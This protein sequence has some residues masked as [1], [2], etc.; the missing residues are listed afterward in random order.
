MTLQAFIDDSASDASVGDYF[1]LAGHVASAEQ[2]VKCSREWAKLLEWAPVNPLTGTH[3]FKMA[4]MASNEE[5]QFRTSAFYRIIE[6]NVICSVSVRLRL[7][8]LANAKARFFA[9]HTKMH[10]QFFKTPFNVAFKTLM[11]QFHAGKAAFA[12]EIPRG[13]PVN[14]IFD[15]QSEKA[16]IFAVW[17]EYL[18]TRPADWR[19]EFGGIPR[20]ENDET[21]LPL[22]AADLWAG[23]VRRW[24][25]AGEIGK[26][27]D[28][29]FGSFHGKRKDHFK[30]DLEL[31]ESD[32]MKMMLDMARAMRIVAYDLDP[33]IV[34]PE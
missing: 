5:G 32:L 19:R 22:Q 20:F 18:A 12:P 28:S 9:P 27:R 17:D 13:E 23:A 15:E 34:R 33:A 4:E 14:F 26:L 16:Q 3:R 25:D 30:L 29:D 6:D 2:W 21:F 31:R 7:S 10:W 11:D 8:A 1:V 24:S